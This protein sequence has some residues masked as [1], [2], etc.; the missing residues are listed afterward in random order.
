MQNVTQL[1]D[2]RSQQNSRIFF[3]RKE[4]DAILNVYGMMVAKG[5]WR[6]YAMGDDKEQAI[7]A[8]FRRA[9]EMPVYRIIKCPKWAKKQG[10]YAIIGASGQ[11]L[12]RGHDLKIAL[13]Y[14]DKKK[15]SV[16]D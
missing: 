12:K 16:V 11:I 6:D 8:I 5:E 1:R 13:R 10:A 14:F 2:Y 3:E 4:L 7:F 9:S 15:F